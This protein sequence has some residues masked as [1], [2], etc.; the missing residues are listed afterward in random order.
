[1]HM[2]AFPT[3]KPAPETP[4]CDLFAVL[5]LRPEELDVAALDLMALLLILTAACK[6]GAMHFG[7]LFRLLFCRSKPIRTASG[8]LGRWLKPFE[9]AGHWETRQLPA[10]RDCEQNS[11]SSANRKLEDGQVVCVH[12]GL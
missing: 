5:P 10:L 7:C 3:P 11:D 12:D 1:M 9:R 6:Q 4:T 2:Q 8:H